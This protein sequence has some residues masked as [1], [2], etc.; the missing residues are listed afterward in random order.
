MFQN[1]SNR[2]SVPHAIGIPSLENVSDDVWLHASAFLSESSWSPH[3]IG[4][5]SLENVSDDVWL[6]A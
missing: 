4:I 5:P 3:A 1:G 6:N 2:S